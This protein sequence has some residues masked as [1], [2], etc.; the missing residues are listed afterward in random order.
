MKKI[1]FTLCMVLCLVPAARAAEQPEQIRTLV[2]E[3][4]DEPGVE[5]VDLGSIAL[6]LLRATIRTQAGNEQDRKALDVLR[7]IKR[8]TVMDL[9]DAAPDVRERFL[10]KAKQALAGEEMLLEAKDGGENVRVYGVSSADGS[11]LHDITVL[12]DD[13]LI[14]I[15][16]KIRMHQIGELIK[17]AEAETR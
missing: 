11:V 5:V 2:N 15:K 4:R 10:R 17:T 7:S 14:C 13:A 12:A 1:L 8:L 9:S 3:Y 16:G 6:G